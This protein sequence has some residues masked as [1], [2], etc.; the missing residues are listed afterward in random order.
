MT[1]ETVANSANPLPATGRFAGREEFRQL[2]RD[3][4]ACAARDG[5][6]QIILSDATF[7]DWPLGELAVAA[8]L[9][10]WARSGRK[11]TL[12]AHRYDGVIRQHARF[13]NWRIQWAHLLDCRRCAAV[14]AQSFPSA[15]WS[16]A[17]VLR[18]LD[19]ERST[20]ISGVEPERRVLLHEDL[21]TC[22]RQS[23]PGFPA[24]TLGL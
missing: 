6:P 7:E 24:V 16:P 12:L 3:A 4:L 23:S 20:G 17:W 5:W 1:T 9:T 8:S 21:Q 22:L 19:L 18:R 14:D 10:A 11:M 2:V 15:I 13:V